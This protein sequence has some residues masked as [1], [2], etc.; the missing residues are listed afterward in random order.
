MQ[1]TYVEHVTHLLAKEYEL[2]AEDTWLMLL[3]LIVLRFFDLR[4][5]KMRALKR[6]TRVSKRAF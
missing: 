6:D 4:W 1:V 2:V 3:S 5:A